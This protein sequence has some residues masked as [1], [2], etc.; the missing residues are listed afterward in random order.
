MQCQGEGLVERRR[1]S[2]AVVEVCQ[3]SRD[4]AGSLVAELEY[5]EIIAEEVDAG[6]Q[7]VLAKG[8]GEVID[9]LVLRNVAAHRVGLVLSPGSECKLPSQNVSLAGKASRAA[10]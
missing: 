8:H 6:L 2:R 5:I 7:C 9:K 1:R 3:G 10:A 4:G